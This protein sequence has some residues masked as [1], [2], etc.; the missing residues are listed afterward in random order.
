MT[1][2]AHVCSRLA[3]A[4]AFVAVLTLFGTAQ[5]EKY[6]SPAEAQAMAERAADAFRAEGESVFA[7]FNEEGNGFHDRDLYVFVWDEDGNA[8]AHGAN[9]GLIGRNFIDLRDVDGKLLIRAFIEVT[10]TGWVDYKW[11]NPTNKN[12]EA[13]TSYIIAVDGLRIGVGAYSQ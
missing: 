7:K 2:F 5:A 6:G 8:V 3:P 10:D 1:N 11:R 12:V 4:A 9:S 13:K